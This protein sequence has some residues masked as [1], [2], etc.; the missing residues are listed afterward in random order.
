VDA[1]HSGV[2]ALRAAGHEDDAMTLRLAA[3]LIREEITGPP[4]APEVRV[5]GRS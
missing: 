3:R 4:R 5:A 1:I 2:S